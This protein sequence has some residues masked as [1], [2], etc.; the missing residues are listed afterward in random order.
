MSPFRVRDPE[1]QWDQ[2][3]PTGHP[4]PR[5]SRLQSSEVTRGEALDHPE[6]LSADEGL[7]DIVQRTLDQDENLAPYA[8]EADVV[9][10]IAR[11]TGIV[12]TLAEKRHAE[13]IVSQIPGIVGFE[14]SISLSTDGSITDRGVEMEVS[15]ELAS[16]P[17]IAEKVG[18][19]VKDGTAFLMGTVDSE[20]EEQMAIDSAY[21]ARGVTDV[22]SRLKIGEKAPIDPDDSAY[23][24]HSQVRNDGDDR[25]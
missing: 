23:L 7:R 2:H 21:K 12:D 18:V 5:E 14:D 16:N 20:E 4:R 22:V 1:T 11:V 6:R 8:L 9:D 17:Q 13:Q 10:G 25:R 19:K 3:R 24:F 15:E